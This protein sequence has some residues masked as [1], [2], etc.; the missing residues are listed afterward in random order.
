MF[1]IFDTIVIGTS[2]ALDVIFLGGVSGDVGQKVAA[3]LF[4]LLIWRMARVV[5]GECIFP[6]EAKVLFCK[7]VSNI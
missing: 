7:S 2:F 1:Q 3:A 5:D 4:V 6:R